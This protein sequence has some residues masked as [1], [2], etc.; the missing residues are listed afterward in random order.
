MKDDLDKYISRRKRLEKKFAANFDSGYKKFKVNV[1]V[2]Q[3]REQ[4]LYYTR[5]MDLTGGD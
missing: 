3:T 4:I 2:R 1:L 5:G